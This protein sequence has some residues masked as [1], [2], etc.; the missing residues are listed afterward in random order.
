MLWNPKSC[1]DF[2]GRM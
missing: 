1:R 2:A